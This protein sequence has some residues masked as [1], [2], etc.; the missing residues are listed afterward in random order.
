MEELLKILRELIKKD[1]QF[2]GRP[3]YEMT[4]DFLFNHIA[5]HML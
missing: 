5:P 4:Q 3:L 1:L 2:H